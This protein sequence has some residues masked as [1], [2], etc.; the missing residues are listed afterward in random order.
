MPSN[1]QKGIIG[2]LIFN[3]IL[4]KYNFKLLIGKKNNNQQLKIQ[5]INSIIVFFCTFAPYLKFCHASFKRTR[6]NTP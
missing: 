1:I 3:V 4:K 5:F 6:N 2:N